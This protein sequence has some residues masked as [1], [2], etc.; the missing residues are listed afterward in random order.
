MRYT[1]LDMP[2]QA[3]DSAAGVCSGFLAN[4]GTYTVTQ[5]TPTYDATFSLTMLY[6]SDGETVGAAIDG[7]VTGCL[8]VPNP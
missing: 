2:G 8:S 5:L 4:A 7:E 3:C 1:E 6:E